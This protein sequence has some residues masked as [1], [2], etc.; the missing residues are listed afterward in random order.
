MYLFC[1][2]LWSWAL[3]KYRDIYIQRLS[4]SAAKARW[5]ASSKKCVPE[6]N[7]K[8]CH[9]TSEIMGR[10]AYFRR[11]LH[12]ASTVMLM[13]GLWRPKFDKNRIL[14][15]EKI[16]HFAFNI[17]KIAIFLCKQVDLNII[18]KVSVILLFPRLICFAEKAHKYCHLKSQSLVCVISSNSTNR[19]AQMRCSLV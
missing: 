12:K 19:G 3:C 13:R 4:T 6:K 8:I 11:S 15:L 10:P 2:F 5:I 17:P 7:V 9:P 1:L 18:A 16:I 14:E